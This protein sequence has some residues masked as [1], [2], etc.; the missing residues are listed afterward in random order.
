[1][2]N[3]LI[4]EW[5]WSKGEMIMAG[6]KG[7]IMIRCERLM[8]MTTGWEDGDMV[9]VWEKQGGDDNNRV[10][11]NDDKAIR[12]MTW[13]EDDVRVIE[14]NND[15]WPYS[16]SFRLGWH[17]NYL[18]SLE[19]GNYSTGSSKLSVQKLKWI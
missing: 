7:T 5:R 19:L 17:A 8:I 15:G 18:A 16:Q 6:Q 9:M 12:I 11:K 2:I 14:E 3:A 10:R 13:W 4:I 1:M